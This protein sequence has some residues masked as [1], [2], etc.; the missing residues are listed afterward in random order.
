MMGYGFGQIPWLNPGLAL[1]REAE[2]LGNTLQQRLRWLE[3]YVRFPPNEQPR[4]GFLEGF[5]LHANTHLNANDRQGLKRLC[6][7]GA[8]SALALKRLPQ[9]EDGF[10]AYQTKRPLPDGTATCSSPRRTLRTRTSFTS[11]ASCRRHSLRR[12][13]C[14]QSGEVSA[15]LQHIRGKPAGASSPSA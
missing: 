3:G 14:W 4:C 7:C 12:Y 8:C 9:A 10:I 6:R 15:L 2:A 11:P 13:V 5:F 1:R